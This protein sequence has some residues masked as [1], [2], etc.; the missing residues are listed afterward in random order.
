[1]EIC[2]E[3]TCITKFILRQKPGMQW[4]SKNEFWRIWKLGIVS[5]SQHAIKVMTS[6]ERQ[7][8]NFILWSH[9]VAEQNNIDAVTESTDKRFRILKRRN[10]GKNQEVCM[11][12]QSWSMFG[13]V[14]H[15]LSSVHSTVNDYS[16]LRVDISNIFL[17]LG[18]FM[19]TQQ[20]RVGKAAFPY[21]QW[22]KRRN[23][24]KIEIMK[25]HI[26]SRNLRGQ[27]INRSICEEKTGISPWVKGQNRLFYI[28]SFRISMDT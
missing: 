13:L 3:N 14:G 21:F 17:L 18:G 5:C 6:D 12:R 28:V 20:Q 22:K 26:A 23:K 24:L 7:R 11:F 10:W 16:H 27:I 4:H 15:C 9:W 1:M 8:N 2:V 25:L 19:V